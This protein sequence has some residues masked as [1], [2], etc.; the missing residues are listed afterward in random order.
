MEG[1]GAGSAGMV[2]AGET[3]GVEEEGGGAGVFGVTDSSAG[4]RGTKGAEGEV[5]G[6]VAME[7]EGDDFGELSSD[8][9]E[10]AD[11]DLEYDEDGMSQVSEMS[12]L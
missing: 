7:G 2:G 5:S 4:S 10:L 9:D 8:D 3:G 1:D 6:S 11:R 12:N